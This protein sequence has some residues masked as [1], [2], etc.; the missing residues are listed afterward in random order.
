MDLFYD[1]NQKGSTIMIAT[2]DLAI[3]DHSPHRIIQLHH[4]KKLDTMVPVEKYISYND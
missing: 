3:Y 2:H 1:L 4:G